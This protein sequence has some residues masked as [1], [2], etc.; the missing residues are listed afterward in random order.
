MTKDGAEAETEDAFLGGALMIRQP[1]KGYRAGVD[2]VLLA[3]AVAG[4]DGDQPTVLDA[5]AGV[6]TAGLSVARRLSG[7]SVVLVER[8][9]PLAQ[10][11]RGNIRQNGLSDRARVVQCDL[12]EAAAD[13]LSAAG[14]SPDT[15]D[16]VLA[17][18]P[19]HAEGY[20]TPAQ[21]DL[22]AV[23]HAMPPATLDHWLR[24]LARM[25]RP[26]GRASV[27]HKADALAEVLDAFGRRFGGLL[28]LPIHPRAGE[29]AIRVLVQGIKGSRAPLR[30]LAPAIL[31]GEGHD[32]TRGA[33]A[34]LRLGA[35]LDLDYWKGFPE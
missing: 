1:V 3:A 15:F 14:L 34:V 7:A 25:C 30:I 21:S 22:K 8:E 4:A 20:G 10:L 13:E 19:F 11:A 23:S 18:P 2:A 9:A 16:H 24:F 26:G 12:V 32:F 33:S 27:I 31:H 5:G 29:P 17:N 35:A 28:V 6:G